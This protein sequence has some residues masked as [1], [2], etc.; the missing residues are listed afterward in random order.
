MFVHNINPVL[1]QIGNLEIRYYGLFYVLGFVIAYFMFNY[2]AKHRHIN[3]DSDDVADFLVYLIVGVV[4]GARIVYVLVY[5][6]LYYFSNPLEAFAVWHG[7]LSF[8]GGFLGAI[9]ASL[10]FLKKIRKNG[11][12]FYQLADITVIPL[13]LG[14]SLG[15]I[16]NFINGELAGRMTDA[17][18]CFKFKGY[19]GCRHPSQLYESAKNLFIFAALWWLKDRKFHG[20]RLK[21]GTLFY[22]FIIMY[23]ILRFFVEFVREPDSQLGYFLGWLTM[24]QMLNVMMLL[25]GSVMLWRIRNK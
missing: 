14:L 17:A 21:D 8:H 20:K 7:G 3:M 10:L 12:T 18:W 4:L 23:S 5:N 2:L 13:A 15:R 9:A 11:V 22:L 24:G 25:V 16:G 6:P 1:F 19:D